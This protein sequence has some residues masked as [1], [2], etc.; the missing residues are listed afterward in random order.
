MAWVNENGWQFEQ[1]TK[2]HWVRRTLAEALV[3]LADT[4]TPAMH[5]SPAA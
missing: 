1:P 4:V 5:K 2:R 3:A